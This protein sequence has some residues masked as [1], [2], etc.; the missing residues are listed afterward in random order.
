MS[1]FDIFKP[2][3]NER[4]WEELK[5]TLQFNPNYFQELEALKLQKELKTYI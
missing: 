5:L 2:R 1:L 3:R 4:K